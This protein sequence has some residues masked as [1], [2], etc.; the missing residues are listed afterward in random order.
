MAECLVLVVAGTIRE[1]CVLT[2]CFRFQESSMRHKNQQLSYQILA[3]AQQRC[4][5]RLTFG[6]GRVL[7]D[8][9]LLLS[10]SGRQMLAR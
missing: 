2:A 9:E 10:Q 4:A 5:K 1:G 7:L 8:E 3:L 6:H